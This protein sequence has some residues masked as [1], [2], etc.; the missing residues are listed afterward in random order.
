VE[1]ESLGFQVPPSQANFVLASSD[2]YPL[3]AA[4]IYTRLKERKILVRYL[5]MRRLDDSMRISIGTDQEV[6]VLLGALN[7]LS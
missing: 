1:L 4:E 5:N 6:D 3:P 2:R 7:D